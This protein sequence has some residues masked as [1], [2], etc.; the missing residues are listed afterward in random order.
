MADFDNS[1]RTQ[2]LIGEMAAGGWAFG[3]NPDPQSYI[4][5]VDG[6]ASDPAGWTRIL[7]ENYGMHEAK[8]IDVNADGW[9]DIVSGQE[10]YNR[11]NPPESARSTGGR[12]PR[13]PRR[14]G[15]R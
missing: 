13:E 4:Y 3:P 15:C 9:L 8:A 2:I 5:R 10:N 12:T 7:V 11:L 14:Q 1:G 6:A